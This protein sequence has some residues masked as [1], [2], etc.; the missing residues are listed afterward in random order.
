MTT[1]DFCKWINK[2]LLPNSTLEPGFPRKVS[3]ETARKWLHKL[4]FEVL[5]PK[6]GIFID[7][8]E[9]PDVVTHRK[10]FYERW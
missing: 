7:G 9:H 8:H 2:C 6:K 10:E 4:G 3:I 5:T 1:M